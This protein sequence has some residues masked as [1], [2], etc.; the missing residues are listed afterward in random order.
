MEPISTN[1]QTD[2]IGLRVLIRP[3][4]SEMTLGIAEGFP[5]S[6]VDAATA[7]KPRTNTCPLLG[8][9]TYYGSTTHAR[10]ET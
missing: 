7:A 5:E 4:V 1:L 6:I 2:Q 9:I 3:A 8:I 10:R